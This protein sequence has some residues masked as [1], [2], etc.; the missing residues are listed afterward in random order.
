MLL[1]RHD[2]LTRPLVRGL[3]ALLARF[4][5]DLGAGTLVDGLAAFRAGCRLLYLRLRLGEA[6]AGTE[7]VDLIGCG[8]CDNCS[9]AVDDVDEPCRDGVVDGLL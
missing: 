8:D 7:E 5:A 3:A 9:G 6:Q 1:G 2:S 4:R